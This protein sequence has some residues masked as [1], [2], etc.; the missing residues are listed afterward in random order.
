MGGGVE[1]CINMLENAF[2]Y[3]KDK[4]AVLRTK[5]DQ[6]AFSEKG[7]GVGE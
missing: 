4:N 6:M 3:R 7:K 1:P 2:R 5:K